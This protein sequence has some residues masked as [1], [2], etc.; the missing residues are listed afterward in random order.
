MF[1]NQKKGWYGAYSISGKMTAQNFIEILNK[2]R[3][4]NDIKRK[5]IRVKDYFAPDTEVK[6]FNYLYDD[7]KSFQKY[8]NKNKHF[9]ESFLKIT[10]KSDTKKIISE[11]SKNLKTFFYKKQKKME[12]AAKNKY[13][14]P[15]Y[16][17][18][19][20]RTLTGINW[21]IMP[22]R[23]KLFININTEENNEKVRDKCLKDKNKDKKINYHLNSESKCYVN[24]DKY[25]QRGNFLE[26][27]DIRFKYDKPYKK[28]KN[29]FIVL[30]ESKNNNSNQSN[31][32]YSK[33][34]NNYNSNNNNKLYIFNIFD[35]NHKKNENKKSL[36][37]DS[38]LKKRKSNLLLKKSL[39][40][41]IKAFKFKN[42]LSRKYFDE[43]GLKK[44]S[45]KNNYLLS[46]SLN[47]DLIREKKN[48]DVIFNHKKTRKKNKIKEFIGINS[49]SF[50]D[51]I[52][53]SD[54]SLNKKTP[55]F[56][57]MTSRSYVEKIKNKCDKPK[58]C[59]GPSYS[60]F[61]KKSFNNII[62]LKMMNSIFFEKKANNKI[63]KDIN[64]IKNNIFFNNK[65]YSQLI[66]ENI[67][68]QLDG[69]TLKTLKNE[70][71]KNKKIENIF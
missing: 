47:Y 70:L 67:L 65:S 35:Y 18:V 50:K 38:L 9:R 25:T 5:K 54:K 60:S 34:N 49:L 19:S 68:N 11:K 36:L 57:L 26:L 56:K 16:D 40:N 61:Y 13:Y 43:L 66:K 6:N 32:I 1:E 59:L 63:K 45:Q 31:S 41:E 58:D 71:K 15:K 46:L 30:E 64:I 33:K 39:S 62:N 53:K 23:K 27:K 21:S 20:P 14:I 48:S 52:D 42:Y 4:I 24:M 3:M 55:N 8:K 28:N 10:N 29:K 37:K 44:N 51:Y 69:I 17:L 12:D 2:D 22:K 7:I